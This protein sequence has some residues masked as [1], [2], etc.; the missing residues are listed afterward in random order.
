MCSQPNALGSDRC[1]SCQEP[2]TTIGQVLS[3][4]TPNRQARFL[5]QARSRASAIKQSEAAASERRL[6]RLQDVDLQRERA[7]LKA[8]QEAKA[9]EKRMLSTTLAIAAVL[10]L[11]ILITTLIITLRG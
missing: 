11:A 6:T 3:R 8:S 7:Q 5:E 10:I 2:L 1:Q 9:R 4:H